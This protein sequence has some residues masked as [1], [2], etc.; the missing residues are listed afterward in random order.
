[1]KIE[2]DYSRYGFYYPETY[3]DKLICLIGWLFEKKPL[4]ISELQLRLHLSPAQ[5][6]QAICKVADYYQVEWI[7]NNPYIARV[8][9]IRQH[10]LHLLFETLSERSI[11]LSV[12]EL[13]R[14]ME[15]SNRE[16]NL[17]LACLEKF[18]D[19]DYDYQGRPYIL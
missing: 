3:L 15:A 18:L 16:I 13:A 9:P 6:N 1:M 7:D 12:E 11:N 19:L 5:V 17:Y 2:I 14:K 10:I 4:P 8:N